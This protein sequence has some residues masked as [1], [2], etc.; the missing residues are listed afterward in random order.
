MLAIK[1]SLTD[2]DQKTLANLDQKNI[3]CRHQQKNNPNKCGRK[4]FG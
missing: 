2:I 4:K 3:L 1:T